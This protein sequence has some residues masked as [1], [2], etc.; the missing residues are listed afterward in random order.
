MCLESPE[1]MVRIL[2]KVIPQTVRRIIGNFWIK[3]KRLT[4]PLATFYERGNGHVLQCCIS[5]NKYG[6]YCVPLSSLHRP[7][8][9]EILAGN[10]YEPE[11][12]EFMRA[13]SPEGDIIHAGSFFGDFIPAISKSRKSDAKIW[14]FEPNLE[15][16][17]C[18]EITILINGL[19]NVKIS[20]VGLGAEKS[21][22]P[23]VIYDDHGRSLGGGSRLVDKTRNY[24]ENQLAEV[25][26]TALDTALPSDRQISIIQLD[27]EGF[28]QHALEGALKTIRRCMPI[29]ILENLPEEDWLN[30]KIFNLG[31]K[32]TGQVHGNTIFVNNTN[33]DA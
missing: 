2:K 32:K 21:T 12:I 29:L 14:A 3:K 1:L 27:V 13:S 20:N 7:A 5:Y 31:Y 18:A 4:R 10:V 33:R 24:H 15:S 9:Q 28:E 8:A 23:M 22:Q 11:T 19:K 16:F 30:K 17:R 26:I 25:E 6:G